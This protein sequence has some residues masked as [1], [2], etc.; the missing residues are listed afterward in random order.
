[1]ITSMNIFKRL[2]SQN[3][4]VKVS[5]KPLGNNPY[6]TP[7]RAKGFQ[8]T[9]TLISS[10]FP[11]F[12]NTIY[13]KTIDNNLLIQFGF[14]HPAEASPETMT[15]GLKNTLVLSSDTAKQLF[16]ALAELFECEVNPKS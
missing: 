9:N 3:T 15:D 1:M 2:S 14:I 10:S 5:Q 6:V 4:S 7:P 12:C 16:C 13:L 8:E 11:Q